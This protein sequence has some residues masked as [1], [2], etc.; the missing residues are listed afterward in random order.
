M[1]LAPTIFL[2]ATFTL[3]AS[4]LEVP[5]SIKEPAGIARKGQPATGGI[6]F[7]QGSVKDVNQLAL[8]DAASE[9]IRHAS[10]LYSAHVEEAPR[11]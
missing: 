1:K 3:A 4:A 8:V 5:V 2:L 6:P 10:A 9:R 7:M 11:S